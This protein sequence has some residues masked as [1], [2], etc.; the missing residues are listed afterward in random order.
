MPVVQRTSSL[1][2]RTYAHIEE[3]KQI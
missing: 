1:A 3:P 2:A